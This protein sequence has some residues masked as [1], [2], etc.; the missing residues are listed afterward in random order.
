MQSPATDKSVNVL[1]CAL[2]VVPV[3]HKRM[4]EQQAHQGNCNRQVYVLHAA[5]DIVISDTGTRQ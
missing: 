2:C 1:A 4:Q 5:F 3:L